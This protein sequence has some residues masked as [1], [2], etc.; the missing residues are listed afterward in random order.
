MADGHVLE[1]KLSNKGEN[2]SENPASSSRQELR[3]VMVRNAAIVQA[4]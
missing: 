4:D 2:P 1:V 3:K